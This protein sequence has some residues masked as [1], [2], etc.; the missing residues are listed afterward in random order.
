MKFLEVSRV[1]VGCLT[2]SLLLIPVGCGGSDLDVVPVKGSVTFNNEPV[3]KAEIMFL[4][5][6]GGSKKPAPPATAVTGVDGTFE[7][8][9][10]DLAG[11]LPGNYKVTVQ[12]TTAA[13]FDIPDPL[14]PGQTRIG[15]MMA[16]NLVP[17]PL[18]PAKYSTLDFTP[19]SFTVGSDP[20]KNNFEIELE[21]AAPPPPKKP[22]PYRGAETPL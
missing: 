21:G 2:C 10:G 17:H 22:M 8:R 14:P 4:R 9:T 16:N 11:A 13:D 6:D 12:K 19:L 18:L 20:E 15:Y 7:L 3:D 1:F 5:T